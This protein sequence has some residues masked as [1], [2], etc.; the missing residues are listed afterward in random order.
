MRTN[1]ADQFPSRWSA[2]APIAL[3]MGLALSLAAS[4]AL[5]QTCPAVTTLATS[6][7][8]GLCEA[9]LGEDVN[10][11]PEDCANP[12]T[13][14]MGYYTQAITCPPTTIYEPTS[15]QNL[16][17]TVRSIVSSGRKLKPA[18][19]SHSA[20]D[21]ICADDLGD[22]VRTK[23]LKDIGAVEPFEGHPT[24]I[25]FEAGIH[26]NEL[27]EH[28][29]SLGYSF[30]LASTGYGGISL[31]GAVATGAHGSSLLS[32]STISSYIVGMDVVGPD[33]N[34]TTYSEGTTGVT[35]PDQWRAL[36][37]NLGLLGLVVRLRLRLEPQFNM[38][39]E[40][41]YQ[42]EATFVANGGVEDTVEDCD[43]VF[44]TWFP[45]QNIVQYLCG[46]REASGGPVH[47]NA[48]NRL[49]TPEIS[50]IEEAFAIPTLQLGMCAPATECFVEQQRVNIYQ[51]QPP[52]VVTDSPS[53]NANVVSRHSELTGYSHRMITL[54]PEVFL[55]QPSLSQLEYEGA[56]PMSQIQGAVQ[57]LN[58]IYDRDDICQPLIG[59]IMRFDV[60]DDGTLLAGNHTRGGISD[61]DRMVH[62]EFVEYWGY[63][64]DEAGLEAFVSNPFSEIIDHLVTNYDY[65]PHWGKNDEWVFEHPSVLA[66]NAGERATFNNVIATMDPYGVFSNES[67]RRN[68]FA[69]PQEGGDF[70]AHYYGACA[71][72]DSDGDGISDCTD[73]T[74]NAYSGMYVRID[75]DG[76]WSGTCNK[77][78]SWSE[79]KKNF[80]ADQKQNMSAGWDY[81]S[82]NHSYHTYTYEWS[83]NW[84]N[85]GG[86]SWEAMMSAK[87]VPEDS[88]RYCFSQDNGATG[89][90]IISGWNACGQIWINKSRVAEVGY[91]STNTPVGCVDLT[92]GEAV[93]LD[94]YNRH[95]NAN[96]SRSFKSKPRWCYGGASNCSPSQ[97]FEQNQLEALEP[98][99]WP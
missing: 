91:Q 71:S 22:V 11:C 10:S 89:T 23:H 7:R 4:E 36:K 19:T 96:V 62:L 74:P 48:Q 56:I 42:N 80:G 37:T 5:A 2:L 66:R 39:V 83:P 69:S 88:G 24:T 14:L 93:R 49:F 9:A 98:V 40:V 59:T 32:H 90:G 60:A 77:A 12:T 13:Q 15:I 82:E 16:Q 27:Q 18:G 95:H 58:S 70:A 64:L 76:V 17:D 26:F 92:G 97:Q 50:G 35:N 87:F 29:H 81:D 25:E 21:V 8:N 44:L 94:F 72:Q 3:I 43:Y 57:Y 1:P 28:L 20:T 41:R 51:S 30:G 52:L 54:Q 46:T 67:S 79:M 78:D 75:D 53:V 61:G 73:R 86:R 65:W 33:G 6:C 38:H 68:G 55:E 99:N 31:G 47:P 63:G 85:S 84:P 45:G 34:L